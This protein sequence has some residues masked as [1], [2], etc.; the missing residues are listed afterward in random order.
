MVGVVDDEQL[1]AA[2]TGQAVVCGAQK[3]GRSAGV[4]DLGVVQQGAERAERDDP[5][6]RS[7]HHPADD[8]RRRSHGELLGGTASDQRL[9]DAVGS[10]QRHAGPL[11]TVQ[12]GRDLVQEGVLRRGNPSSR[13]CRI[14]WRPGCAACG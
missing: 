4:G 11:R 8:G 9:A 10:D 7:A 6:R 1:L 12:G 13:H 5:L 14:L 3:L 2:V